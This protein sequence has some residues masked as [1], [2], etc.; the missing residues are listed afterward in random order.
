MSESE[1]KVTIR[2]LL[3]AFKELWQ[4]ERK[5]HPHLFWVIIVIGFVYAFFAVFAR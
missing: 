3:N 4:E 2:G 5:K 1:E